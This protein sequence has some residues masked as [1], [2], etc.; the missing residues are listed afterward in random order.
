[1]EPAR[2]KPRR[3]AE[4]DRQRVSVS[5]DRCKTRKIRCIRINGSDDPCAACVQLKVECAA[6][7]PRKQRVYA[8]YD[9]LQSRYRALDVLVKKLYPGEDLETTENI[10]N[11][12]RRNGIQLDG[13]DAPVELDPLPPIPSS[14]DASRLY[15]SVHQL[16]IPEGALIPAPR[17]GYHYVG[18][19]S[20]YFFANTIR[21]LVKKSSIYHLALDRRAYRRQ[22][23]A[24]EFTSANRT[25]ALEARIHGHPIM[26]AEDETTSPA[27]AFLSE[28]SSPF[29]PRS[30]PR[31]TKW[32]ADMLPPRHLSD[33]LIGAFFDR[34]NPNFTLLH[35]AT[36]QDQ[37]EPIWLSNHMVDPGWLCVLYMIYVLG[38]QALERDGLAD[39]SGI[40]SR[41]L[42]IVVRDGLQRLVLTA[43]QAN[44]QAL[45]LLSLYQHNAGERNTAWMLIGH[46]AHM[47]VALGM[48][49]DQTAEYTFNTRNLRRMIWWTLFLF[50]QNLSFVLGRP[51]ATS[52]VDISA[53]LP[54]ETILD[55]SNAP[56]GYLEHAVKLG[57]I[58]A[59]VKRFVASISSDY[60]KPEVL[61]ST[62]SM[63]TQLGEIL[64]EWEMSLPP[65]LQLDA[66]FATP[67]H[68]RSVLL[69]HANCRHLR[70]VNSRPYLLC[71]INHD[72]S[73]GSSRLTE[74]I[75]AL[76]EASISAARACMEIMIRLANLSMLEGELWYDYY[77]VHHASL[78]LSL[79]L[80]VN[81][82]DRGDRA[83]VSA[84][85][86]YA[87]RTRLAPTYRI[88]INVSI[89]FAKIVGIGPD[90][91]T[92][93][94]SPQPVDPEPP[95]PLDASSDWTN[96][97]LGP[98]DPW[99]LGDVSSLPLSLEQLLGM[100]GS[101]HGA[102]APSDMHNFGFTLP[103]DGASPSAGEAGTD[104]DLFPW[105][106]F[107]SPV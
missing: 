20:S 47:A 65:H 24:D 96:P 107:R 5:C 33:K 32:T 93:P 49:R 6:T 74:A 41:Y 73:P 10:L 40:Q 97:A 56:P 85:L 105:D 30:I 27:D 78:I 84:A 34:V 98:T 90:D 71:R 44:V 57:A 95:L 51:S 55:G 35:R 54:D 67:K 72:V 92:R 82:E 7:L 43:T 69:L 60:D 86:N 76:A 18:P 29:T 100:Q 75:E 45:A 14:D 19:A 9:Q 3:V 68:A 53:R 50:E 91:E 2:K 88:L 4:A 106:F 23:R 104:F 59:K 37:Y 61:A 12:A 62:T 8:S 36:F 99:S 64:G 31:S 81:S 94:S 79:P 13:L 101:G 52:T 21:Q 39:A 66:P 1:M 83:L 87:Q 16:H 63:A 77:L 22:Q 15:E 46:A 89:Q 70:S 25:T 11:L 42:A 48:Q 103:D 80:L 26:T 58:S 102:I 17:G 38:A 28:A